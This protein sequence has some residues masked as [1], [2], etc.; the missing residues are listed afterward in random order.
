MT[1]N[2]NQCSIDSKYFIPRGNIDWFKN[3]ILSP[4]DFEEGNMDK[5]PPTIYVDISVK[6]DMTKNILL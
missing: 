3:L 6:L 5:I 4:D 2:S 1:S